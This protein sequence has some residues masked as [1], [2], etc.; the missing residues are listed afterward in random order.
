MSLFCVRLKK[1][2][3]S[4]EA[5]ERLHSSVKFEDLFEFKLN[6]ED[7]GFVDCF[8]AS[9]LIDDLQGTENPFNII[10]E[11]YHLTDAEVVSS[12]EIRRKKAKSEEEQRRQSKNYVRFIFSCD[13]REQLK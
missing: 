3:L 9:L 1:V 13:F 6:G 8:D 10:A 7:R 11:V 5:K 12:S 2:V 4:L